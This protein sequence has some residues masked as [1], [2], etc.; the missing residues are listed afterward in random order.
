[1]KRFPIRK[2]DE[3]SP[4]DTTS[5]I[6]QVCGGDGSGGLNINDIRERIQIMDAA[7]KPI[8]GN[9]EMDDKQHKKL[10]ELLSAFQF[11]FAH[12]GLLTILDDIMGAETVKGH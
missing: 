2:P 7:E 11:A 5:V 6:T 10:C 4:F 1:M 3:K 12:R 8:N 9:I